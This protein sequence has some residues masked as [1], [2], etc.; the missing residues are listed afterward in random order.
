MMHCFYDLSQSQSMSCN[1]QSHFARKRLHLNKPQEKTVLF[2]WNS[3]KSAVMFSK[4]YYREASNFVY[5]QLSFFTYSV[6][7]TYTYTHTSTRACTH[8]KIP[9]SKNFKTS[10]AT[11]CNFKLSSRI[12]KTT[13]LFPYIS[14]MVWTKKNYNTTNHLGHN[15]SML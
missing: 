4:Y 3:P 12:Q 7:S 15:L 6:Y 13:P 1:F 9:D 5:L 2:N 11:K 10:T 14:Y 8:R